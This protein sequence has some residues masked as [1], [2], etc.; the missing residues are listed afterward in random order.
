MLPVLPY[1]RTTVL[2]YARSIVP[3]GYYLT[4]SMGVRTLPEIPVLSYGRTPE[5]EDWRTVVRSY[6]RTCNKDTKRLD[7]LVFTCLVW[8][9]EVISL[10]C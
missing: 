8:S 6:H 3:F 9:Y 2:W 1:G 5:R 7:T 10:R 4:A